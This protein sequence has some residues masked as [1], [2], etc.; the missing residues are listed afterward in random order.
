MEET[1]DQLEHEQEAVAVPVAKPTLETVTLRHLNTGDTK[2]VS[3][4][5]EEMIPLMS[6]GYYQVKGA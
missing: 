4:T 2:T 1:V 3:A 6:R 5:P